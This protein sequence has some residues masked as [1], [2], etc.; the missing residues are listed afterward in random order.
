M[1]GN[2]TNQDLFSRCFYTFSFAKLYFGEERK[3]ASG[4]S[5]YRAKCSPSQVGTLRQCLAAVG[6]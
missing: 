6:L 5:L 2:L 3:G 4:Y 1:F